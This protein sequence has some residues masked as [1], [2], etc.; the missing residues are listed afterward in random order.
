MARQSF[1]NAYSQELPKDSIADHFSLF[2]KLPF[3]KSA[4]IC[5]LYAVFSNSK[6]LRFDIHIFTWDR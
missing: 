1:L 4:Y 3:L 5:Y 6:K 2:A